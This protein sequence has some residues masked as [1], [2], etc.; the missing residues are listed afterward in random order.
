ME[1]LSLKM[2]N[3]PENDQEEFCMVQGTPVIK[4]IYF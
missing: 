2:G 1:K 4:R 3:I